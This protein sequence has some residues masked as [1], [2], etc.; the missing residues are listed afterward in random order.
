MSQSFKVYGFCENKCAREVM[1]KE[2]IEKKFENLEQNLS[3]LSGMNA[4]AIQVQSNTAKIE[5][6]DGISSGIRGKEIGINKVIKSG[7]QIIVYQFNKEEYDD[8]LEDGAYYSYQICQVPG[9]RQSIFAR[10]FTHEK[11]ENVTGYID[12]ILFTDGNKYVHRQRCPL[13]YYRNCKTGGAGLDYTVNLSI[14]GLARAV[15]YYAPMDKYVNGFSNMTIA[16][17]P[18][19]FYVENAG[20]LNGKT[21][22]N[23]NEID[24]ELEVNLNLSFN[25]SKI[26][27]QFDKLTGGAELPDVG[28]VK[29]YNA[30]I[31]KP[32]IN[33]VTLEGELTSKDLGLNGGGESSLIDLGITASPEEL[34]HMSGVTS[35]VQNQLDDKAPAKHE[36]SEY[37]ESKHTHSEYSTT[38][39]I[40]SDTEPSQV[41]E[42]TVV[43]VY[44]V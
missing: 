43:M 15:N 38:K 8:L 5:A 39:I 16:M 41:A 7:E 10:T 30:L 37:A 20:A 12:V 34:N 36:H 4:V 9:L 23:V 13:F 33:G 1:L 44:E 11:L 2:D 19:I 32:K 17:E 26:G 35:P 28:N 21:F 6:L 3:E 14:E 29:S 42:N 31:D 24:I 27:Y 22:H 25:C 40:F 18:H